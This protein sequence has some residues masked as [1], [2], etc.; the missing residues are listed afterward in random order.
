MSRHRFGLILFASA[1]V[2]SPLAAKAATDLIDGVPRMDCAWMTSY[3]DQA[4]HL[5]TPSERENEFQQLNQDRSSYMRLLAQMPSGDR[6]KLLQ[7]FYSE[8]NLALQKVAL[9]TPDDRDRE[10]QTYYN[11]RDQY[12]QKVGL[13]GPDERARELQRYFDFRDQYLQKMPQM[14]GDQRMR[15]MRD[16]FDQRDVDMNQLAKSGPAAPILPA[17]FTETSACSGG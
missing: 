11:F 14:T 15:D 3:K 12:L 16:Y 2:A 1:V 10:L 5:L 13:F 7:R 9:L 4:G 8:R 6:D 17:S